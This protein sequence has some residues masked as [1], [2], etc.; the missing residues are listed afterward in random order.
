MAHL[1]EVKLLN[2]IEF[3]S[4]ESLKYKGIYIKIGIVEVSS[5]FFSNRY[6]IVKFVN[7]VCL[8]WFPSL[9]VCHTHTHLYPI[10]SLHFFLALLLQDY[11]VRMEGEGKVS[12]ENE[13]QNRFK[14]ICVFCGSRVG[15]KSAFS[16]AALELGKLMVFPTLLLYI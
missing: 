9:S 4:S 2:G 13:N 7:Q 5:S 1:A 12:A 14:R 11:I 8:L 6:R 15:Y 16:D 10:S 3:S